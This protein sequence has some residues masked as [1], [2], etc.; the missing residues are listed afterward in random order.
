MRWPRHL[1]HLGPGSALH[2]LGIGGAGMS[3]LAE[4]L[5]GLGYCVSGCDAVASEVLE[6]LDQRG[7]TVTVGHR[8][9]HA[10][11][12]DLLVLT[13]A[14]STDHPEIAAF[15]ARRRPVVKRAALLGWLSASSYTIAV[16]GTHGKSTTSGMITMILEAAGLQPGFLIGAPLRNLDHR[17]A[18]PGSGVHLVVEAD[19]YDYS[20]LTLEPEIAVVLNIDHDHPDL[21]PNLASVTRAFRRFLGRLRPG[22]TAILSADDPAT[23]Q[24]AQEL[25]AMDHQ[26]L[27]FGLA[28]RAQF[29]VLPDGSLRLPDGQTWPLHLLVPG[30]HNRTNAAAA[31]AAATVLGVAPETAFAALAQFTGVGRRFEDWGEINGTRLIVDYAHHPREVAATLAAAR[32]CFPGARLW[33]V[34]QPHTYSRTA[35]FLEEF[36]RT[37]EMADLVVVSEVYAA[38]EKPLAGVSGDILARAIQRVPAI[39]VNDPQAAAQTIAAA[40]QPGDVVLVLGAGD[41]WKTAALL[42]GIAEH[43]TNS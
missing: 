10:D 3:G 33:A 27:T 36:A 41:I 18:R 19:E 30:W 6:R 34:F 37:L 7:I 31:V 28:K 29:R 2:F 24:L 35:Q 25:R 8:P 26:V 1:T 13:S 11:L 5:A 39:A 17:S 14:A 9:E 15:L 23:G 43:A 16:A 20:F 38:R 22:G 4:L 40:M 42:K 12:A 21:F 32:E